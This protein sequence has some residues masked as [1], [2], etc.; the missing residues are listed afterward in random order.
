MASATFKSSIARTL[1]ARVFNLGTVMEV[2][3]VYCQTGNESHL[4]SG[5]SAMH[6]RTLAGEIR[7][8]FAQIRSVVAHNR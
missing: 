1:G 6:N 5:C 2:G 3:V 7:P 8:I 4:V